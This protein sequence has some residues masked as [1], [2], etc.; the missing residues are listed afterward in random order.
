MLHLDWNRYLSL[1]VPFAYLAIAAVKGGLF[2]IAVVAALLILPLACIWESELV[3][4]Y[5]GPWGIRYVTKRSP[6]KGV[7]ILGWVLLLSPIVRFPISR[8]VE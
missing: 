3:G 7:L 4:D 8:S 6:A 2:A 1:L 5:V